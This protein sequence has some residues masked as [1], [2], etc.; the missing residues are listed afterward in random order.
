MHTSYI[1]NTTVKTL[2][3]KSIAVNRERPRSL[4]FSEQWK[5]RQKSISDQPVPIQ[6]TF[7]EVPGAKGSRI[8]GQSTLLNCPRNK[9]RYSRDILKEDLMFIVCPGSFCSIQAGSLQLKFASQLT[10]KHTDSGLQ[11]PQ[12]WVPFAE[13]DRSNGAM[14][15]TKL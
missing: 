10:G 9:T 4:D 3:R 7:K 8:Q 5:L 15:V 13:W 11:Y 2:R 1:Y 12:A 6:D 14:A